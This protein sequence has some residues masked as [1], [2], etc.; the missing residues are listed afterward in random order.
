MKKIFACLFIIT[1]SLGISY[2]LL[3]KNP[4]DQKITPN[5]KIVITHIKAGLGNQFFKYAAG[6][7]LA[8]RLNAELWLIINNEAKIRNF[9]PTERPFLLDLFNI[10]YDKII[11]SNDPL[12]LKLPEFNEPYKHY[13]VTDINYFDFKPNNDHVSKLQVYQ[14]ND[15]YDSYIYFQEFA[16]DLKQLFTLKNSKQSLPNMEKILK[17]ESVAVHVRRGDYKNLGWT[18][19]IDYQIDAISRMRKSL[20]NPHFFLFSDDPEY[21]KSFAKILPDATVVSYEGSNCIEEFILMTACKHIV[22]SN[23][24]FSWWAAWLNKNPNKIVIS[25]LPRYPDSFYNYYDKSIFDRWNGIKKKK[26]SIYENGYPK[27]WITI[28]YKA[29]K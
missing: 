18:M 19:P 16:S 22:T 23:S 25:P 10:E 17:S 9:T 2:N 4:L 12:N 24:T 26:M 20:K 29:D 6:Y 11:F 28:N 5:K 8:K 3:H 15:F 14:L 21:L 27:E 13:V 1:A 7:S